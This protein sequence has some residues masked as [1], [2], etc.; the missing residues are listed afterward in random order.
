MYI[1]ICI[2]IEYS[3]SMYYVQTQ[4]SCG[5]FPSP[6]PLLFPALPAV[7]AEARQKEMLLGMVTFGLLGERND[8]RT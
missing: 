1:Y 4:I 6:A 2:C 5:G 3:E 7:A 8:D